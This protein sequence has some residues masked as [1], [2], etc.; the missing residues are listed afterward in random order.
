MD[1]IEKNHPDFME[2]TE[3]NNPYFSGNWN[4]ISVENMESFLAGIGMGWICRKA[5]TFVFSKC[6]PSVKITIDGNA[7]TIVH[8]MWKDTEEGCVDVL[9]VGEETEGK[10]MNGNKQKHF[11]SWDGNKLKIKTT[12]ED[13]NLPEI[14]TTWDLEGDIITQEHRLKDVVFV[15]KLQKKKFLA[16]IKSAV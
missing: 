2:K 4:I 5:I 14:E 6:P 9:K 13:F 12:G 8:Y 11:T 3:T 7:I 1:K 10:G 15:R 16:A